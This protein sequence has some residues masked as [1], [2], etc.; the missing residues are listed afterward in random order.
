MAQG[1]DGPAGGLLMDKTGPD[2]SS[3]AHAEGPSYL[4]LCVRV[5]GTHRYI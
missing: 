5:G 3:H 2:V 1:G 4:G